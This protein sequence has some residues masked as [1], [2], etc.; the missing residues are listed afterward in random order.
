MI[1]KPK[2]IPTSLVL[3]FTTFG[4]TLFGGSPPSSLEGYKMT[5]DVVESDG[6]EFTTSFYFLPN[7][8]RLAEDWEQGAYTWSRYGSTGT[9]LMEQYSDGKF[10][11]LL[12]FSNNTLQGKETS[13]TKSEIVGS[14]TF[15][16]ANYSDDDLPY[17]KFFHDD[18]TSA[19][20]S[21]YIWG[22]YSKDG[23]SAKIHD[24]AYTMYGTMTD[25]GN[26]WGQEIG[27]RSLLG[28]IKTG[29]YKVLLFQKTERGLSLVSSV[30]WIPSFNWKFI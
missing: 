13:G 24:G 4:Q 2:L 23:F 7:G 9:I 18:F 5:I 14:G 3:L 21:E 6:N 17:G 1:N 28:L 26:R 15:T 27:A 12:N 20:E 25:D 11:I 30:T 8:V 22:N 29:M 16:L 19:A 10:E